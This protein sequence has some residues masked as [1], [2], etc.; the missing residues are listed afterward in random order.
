MRVVHAMAHEMNLR[1]QP[2]AGLVQLR[3]TG[4]DHIGGRDQ[5]PFRR[6]HRRAVEALEATEVIHAV[7]HQPFL[8]E[9]A[10]K[11]SDVGGESPQLHG[12]PRTPPL[13]DDDEN[14]EVAVADPTESSPQNGDPDPNPG[15]NGD[16]PNGDPVT[17]EPANGTPEDPVEPPPENG[18]DGGVGPTLQPAE[19]NFAWVAGSS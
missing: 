10:G 19:P 7:V 14:G 11:K 13:P 3:G 1:V 5:S 9:R 8:A 2:R 12:L 18:D 15:E 6:G 4:D 17:P 16:D